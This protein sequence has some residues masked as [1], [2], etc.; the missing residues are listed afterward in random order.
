MELD[1]IDKETIHLLVFLFMQ[2]LSQ[3]EQAEVS[4]NKGSTEYAA[5]RKC[6]QR[7]FSLLGFDS[8]EMRFT[9]MPHKVRTTAQFSSFFANLAQVM[10]N[11]FSIGNLLL[12]N[13]VLILH[14][15]EFVSSW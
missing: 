11:N 3:P 6:F 1:N 7:L 9:T 8:K 5:M 12:N 15:V 13:I 14:K 4:E 2:F 10:D